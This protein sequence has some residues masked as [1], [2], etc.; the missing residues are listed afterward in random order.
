MEFFFVHPLI[1][2]NEE[3]STLAITAYITSKKIRSDASHN[4]ENSNL[5]MCELFEFHSVVRE[6][7][8]ATCANYLNLTA[9]TKFDIF[10][11]FLVEIKNHKNI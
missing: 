10:F 9:Q 1:A 3:N 11:L 4:V 2:Q 8:E 6:F 7:I 5:A